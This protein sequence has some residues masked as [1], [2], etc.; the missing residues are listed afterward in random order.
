MTNRSILRTTLFVGATALLA[1]NMACTKQE[2]PAPKSDMAQTADATPIKISFAD[3]AD[4]PFYQEWDTPFG[5]PPFSKISD[6]DYQPA[7]DYAIQTLSD[8]ISALSASTEEPTFENTILYMERAGKDLT[9][10]AGVFGNITNTDTNE[11]LQ[12]LERTIYPR[13]SQVYDSVYLDDNIWQRVKTLYE[14]RDSLGLDAAEMRLLELTHRDFVR[15]GANLSPQAKARMKEI[16]AR[17]SQL[18]TQFGQNLLKETKGFELVVT[19]E[20]EL[21]GVPQALKD[22]AKAKATRKGYENAWV[23]GLDRSVYESFMTNAENRNLRQQLFEGYTGR[24]AQGN[25]NDNGAV[26]IEIAQLRAEAAKL[27]GYKSHAAY[28]LETRMAK[29]PEQAEAFLLK[30]WRPGLER[31]KQELTDMQALVDASGDDYTVRASDWWYLSEKVRQEKYAFD[32][33][34]LKPFFKLENVRQGAF[35]VANKLWGVTFEP[36]EDVP[37]WNPEVIA[38][39]MKDKDGSL[40]GIYMTDNYARESKRGGAWMSSYRSASNLD[41]PVR[42]IITNN[43][44]LVKPPE[45][46]PT[47]MGFTE[48]TTLFHEFGHGLH[49]LM[50]TQKFQRFSGVSGPRDYTEFPA[51]LMEHWASEPDVLAVYA[52]H[53][54]TGEI[55]PQTLV[56]KM[57]AASNHNQ[58]FKTTEYIAASLLDLAWHNLTLE[59]ANSITDARAFERDVLEGYGLIDEIE[60]RYRSPYFSH[61]FAGGY[62]AGY[63]AYLWSEILDSDGFDAFKE[64]GDIFDQTLAQKLRENVYE[65]GGKQEA[66][67]LYR[68]FR[69]K[70]PSIEPLLRNRGLDNGS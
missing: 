56:D 47:L 15:S 13:L 44:N 23:F 35:Y 21:A 63:Y 6:E 8:E 5:I 20:A 7:F 25:E 24:A 28:Q 37:L 40:L 2:S 39:E 34:Q 66:D 4:N 3:V 41:E 57:K 70:D 54:E 38:Y 32:D 45:G 30:V 42:P 11:T 22:A 53:V 51:Q 29:T 12:G 26:I 49:G 68:Q 43:L 64:S 9:R 1:L 60:P 36:L 14:N 46:D 16:N 31:A 69:G 19:D 67:E 62:S 33:S 48:V 55:I 18:T 10:V 61:I 59:E 65:A 50:T 58:G 52:T 27:R 17:L